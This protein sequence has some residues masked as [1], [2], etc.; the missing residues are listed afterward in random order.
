M[1]E[2]QS[3][4]PYTQTTP[5]DNHRCDEGSFLLVNIPANK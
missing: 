3:T 2:N 4:F 5:Q 1:G